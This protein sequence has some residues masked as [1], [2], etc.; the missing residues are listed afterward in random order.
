[1][2]RSIVIEITIQVVMDEELKQS[3]YQ[4]YSQR[5]PE[6]DLIYQ[7]GIPASTS[8]PQVYRDEVAI[9]SD[10]VG[11]FCRGDLIDLACG[12]AFWLPRY[13]DRC[14]HITLF[15]QSQEMLA[16]AR[17]RVYSAGVTG[18]TTLLTG[19]VFDHDFGQTAYDCA[20]V[21][22]LLSH[23]TAQQ[24]ADLFRSFKSI[25]KPK[26]VVLILD[27][28]WSDDRARTRSKEGSQ[29]R[30]LADGRQFRIY[31]KH[32]TRDDLLAMKAT[33][34]IRLTIEHF[35][36]VFFAARVTFE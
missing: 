31:K 21:G 35:G 13:G 24:E 11:D 15:D 22:F 33:H 12:T 20:L 8:D 19:D 26:G 28:A 23:V 14:S 25:V 29:M 3:M 18:R 7:G 17:E 16:E 30:T 36:N 32:F 9:L 1:M 10:I 6:Y 4:Y 27:S 5:A 34:E 2:S